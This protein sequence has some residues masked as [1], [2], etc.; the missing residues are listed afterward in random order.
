MLTMAQ[1]WKIYKDMAF[2]HISSGAAVREN[3]TIGQ[4]VFVGNTKIDRI[5]IQN[6]SVY[7]GVILEDA[8]FVG[9]SVV[10]TNVNNPRA[11]VVR[12][13]EQGDLVRRQ[14]GQTLQ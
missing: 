1:D 7:D 5:Q 13:H 8:V 6:V 12:R 3:V 11:A 4:N 14:F 10:F 9:P 2:F